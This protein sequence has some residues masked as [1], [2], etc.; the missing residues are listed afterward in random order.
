MLRVSLFAVSQL[1]MVRSSQFSNK[2][3]QRFNAFISIEDICIISE[4]VEIEFVRGILCR[5]RIIKK[6][7]VLR[8]TLEQGFRYSALLR[9]R[10][11]DLKSQLFA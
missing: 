7:A 9:F 4:K 6:L 2:G 10:M 5:L 8:Q 3:F 1:Y 11:I